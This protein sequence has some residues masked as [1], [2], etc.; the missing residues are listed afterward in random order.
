MLYDVIFELIRAG[1]DDELLLGLKE[2]LGDW[3]IIKPDL[4]PWWGNTLTWAIVY[5]R[6]W[7]IEWLLEHGL[8][9]N[10]V[11]T[12]GHTAMWTATII[13][14]A[15][16]IA[17]LLDRSANVADLDL[18]YA[19]RADVRCVE[20][21]LP[22]IDDINIQGHKNRTPLME[23]AIAGRL[24]N[25]RLLLEHGADLKMQTT[26]GMTALDF[27]KKRQREDIVAFLESLVNRVE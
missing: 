26:Y 24:E 5:N 12:H 20:L 15:S 13:G 14:N 9:I 16:M 8:D 2:H 22:H 11:N 19:A 23:A 7:V 17:L 1:S 21:I 25:V 4:L 10:T 27:A 6:P 3:P 18:F